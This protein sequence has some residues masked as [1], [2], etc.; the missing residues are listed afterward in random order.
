VVVGL[1]YRH[2]NFQ[3]ETVIPFTAAGVGVLGN[4]YVTTPQ[5]D[6]FS[7]RLSYLFSPEVKIA[8]RPSASVDGFQNCQSG[9]GICRALFHSAVASSV[10]GQNAPTQ[11]VDGTGHLPPIGFA[12]RWQS[13][14]QVTVEWA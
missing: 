14:V 2:Y 4:Q 3:S 5:F 12:C 7:F 8:P 10:P 6:T 1:E 9:P 13:G 11:R